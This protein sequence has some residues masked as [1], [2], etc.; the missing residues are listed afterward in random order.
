MQLF[1]RHL[2]RRVIE[3]AANVATQADVEALT[4]DMDLPLR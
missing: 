2:T 4:R 3:R 1:A